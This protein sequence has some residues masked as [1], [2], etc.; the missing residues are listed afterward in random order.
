MNNIINTNT[1]DLR[2][3]FFEDK[4]DKNQR[5][6]IN[7]TLDKVDS[8]LDLDRGFNFSFEGFTDEEKD[9]TLKMI[10]TLLKKGIVGHRYYDSNGKIEKHFLIP[11]IGN[12][13]LYNA[14]QDGIVVDRLI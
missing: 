10:A 7:K 5:N 9:D 1:N 4:I 3:K 14:K 8:F 13:R 12:S 6:S 11:S 2:N